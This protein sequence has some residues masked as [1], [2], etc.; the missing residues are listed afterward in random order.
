M[1]P[2]KALVALHL[3]YFRVSGTNLVFGRKWGHPSLVDLI[4]IL[5]SGS[6]TLVVE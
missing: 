6:G 4:S 5:I 1:Q 2:Q 3:K